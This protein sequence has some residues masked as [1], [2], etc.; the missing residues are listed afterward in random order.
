MTVRAV[1]FD[2]DNTIYP[3]SNGLMLSI[4]QRIGEFV[5]RLLG[6]DE[7]EALR[8]RRHYYAEYGTTLRGLQHHHQDHRVAE[9][10]QG[11][12]QESLP[13]ACPVERGGFVIEPGWTGS[14]RPPEREPQPGGSPAHRE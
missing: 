12:A 6:L 2:L 13:D 10:R 5:Q 8:L 14:D 7:D 3:A 9:R 4:D 11:D 1:L